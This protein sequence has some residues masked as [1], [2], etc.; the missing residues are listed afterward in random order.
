MSDDNKHYRILFRDEGPEIGH[1]YTFCTFLDTKI[2]GKE[3]DYVFK[4]CAFFRCEFPEDFKDN[5]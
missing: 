5:P 2:E 4:H 3:S 1:E